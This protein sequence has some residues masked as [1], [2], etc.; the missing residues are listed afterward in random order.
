VVTPQFFAGK[1]GE[2]RQFAVFECSWAVDEESRHREAVGLVI[3]HCGYLISRV[4]YDLGKD[5]G[6]P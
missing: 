1:C 3:W 6:Y 4:R 5:S 2:L